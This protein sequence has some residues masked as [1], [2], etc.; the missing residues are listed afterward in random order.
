[1]NRVVVAVALIASS[2]IACTSTTGGAGAGSA[3]V[4]APAPT[5]TAPTSLAPTTPTPAPSTPTSSAGSSPSGP[6]T[7]RVV[8]RPV[9]ASRAAAAGWTV[10]DQPTPILCSPAEPSP[11]AVDPGISFCSPSAAFALACWRVDSRSALCA[12]DLA[13]HVL[14][15][16]PLSGPFAATGPPAQPAPFTMTLADGSSCTIRDG[17]TGEN[18]T[19]HPDWVQYYFCS[20]DTAVY[21]PPDGTGIDT[22][23]AEWRVYVAATDGEGD[24]TSVPV[25][26]AT[27]VGTASG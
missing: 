24:V 22:S 7:T 15:R 26:T 20:G 3:S 14:A 27:F 5:S 6:V 19:N 25:R 17:G 13:R 8:L 2:A 23:A 18:L 11:V 16:Y 4:S 10:K 12:V 1:M 21:A 9:T